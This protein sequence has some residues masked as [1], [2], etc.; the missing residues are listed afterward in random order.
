[1]GM[2]SHYVLIMNAIFFSFWNEMVI[3]IIYL[4]I[5]FTSLYVGKFYKNIINRITIIISMCYYVKFNF[6]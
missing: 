1:M 4:F 3:K 5:Y 6:H 2:N